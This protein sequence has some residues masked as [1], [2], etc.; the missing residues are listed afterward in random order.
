M[1][2]PHGAAMDT[3]LAAIKALKHV[4]SEEQHIAEKAM[5]HATKQAIK[6]TK[7]EATADMVSVVVMKKFML[8]AEK[9]HMKVM[10]EALTFLKNEAAAEMKSAVI[11]MKLQMK[12][13]DKKK[14]KEKR[15]LAN[16]KLALIDGILNV[17][18]GEKGKRAIRLSNEVV[19]M[20]QEK[21]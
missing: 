16:A 1:S 13:A 6:D 8:A 4:K 21:E 3:M 12:E 5:K 20:K 17:L 9:A 10:Q 7:H 15:V 2:S 11:I 14:R 18:K 19:N